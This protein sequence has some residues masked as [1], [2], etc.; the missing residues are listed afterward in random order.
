MISMKWILINVHASKRNKWSIPRQHKHLGFFFV[1]RQHLSS[2][3][4][5]DEAERHLVAQAAEFG[6]R[7]L[8]RLGERVLEVVAP[9]VAE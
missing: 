4:L 8:R 1:Q 5:R 3:A 7:Y 2:P 9:E 6:P